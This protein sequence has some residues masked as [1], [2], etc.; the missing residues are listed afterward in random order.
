MAKDYTVAD[1]GAK[2][3]GITINTRTIQK[4]IACVH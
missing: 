1:F 3:D 4:A 2:N